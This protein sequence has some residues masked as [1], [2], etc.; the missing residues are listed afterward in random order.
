MLIPH[1]QDYGCIKSY[2][3]PQYFIQEKFFAKIWGRKEGIP[4]LQKR[5][6]GVIPILALPA[7]FWHSECP[8]RPILFLVP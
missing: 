4:L 6:G 8:T 7:P 5:E 1:S 3:E 2:K